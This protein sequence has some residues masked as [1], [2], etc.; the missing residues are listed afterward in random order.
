MIY[1]A[2]W[3]IFLL[4]RAWLVETEASKGID[5]LILTVVLKLSCEVLLSWAALRSALL[6]IRLP[7]NTNTKRI[8]LRTL[9]ISKKWVEKLMESTAGGGK[10]WVYIPVFNSEARYGKNWHIHLIISWFKWSPT[11]GFKESSSNGK[12]SSSYIY[13]DSFCLRHRRCKGQKC[14]ISLHFRVKSDVLFTWPIRKV[15]QG[16]SVHFLWKGDL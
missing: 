13:R 7:L 9:S 1:Q 3:M 15:L 10:A 4:R 6:N 16:W 2:W 14:R 8:D 5:C 11:R 12:R